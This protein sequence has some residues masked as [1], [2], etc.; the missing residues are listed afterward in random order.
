MNQNTN[1]IQL[2]IN[3]PTHFIRTASDTQKL[4][5]DSPLTQMGR[6]FPLLSKYDGNYTGQPK[7]TTPESVNF[8][9]FIC[10][11]DTN[12]RSAILLSDD[13][14]KAG[15]IE[16]GLF[17]LKYFQMV[18]RAHALEYYGD[19]MK[20]TFL[21]YIRVQEREGANEILPLDI[22]SMRNLEDVQPETWY[23]VANW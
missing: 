3:V 6:M 4:P 22:V 14:G 19:W 5:E 20:L 17:N 11:N 12:N 21:Q 23:S 2:W 10:R 1:P 15:G 9:G 16:L 7:E 13:M 8:H 18:I